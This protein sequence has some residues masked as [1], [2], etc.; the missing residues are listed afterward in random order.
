M[1][2][3]KIRR[4]LGGGGERERAGRQVTRTARAFAFSP[5]SAVVTS[6]NGDDAMSYLQIYRTSMLLF[7]MFFS[8]EL[9][10]LII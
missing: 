9:N 6:N 8:L 1:E 5:P 3:N 10:W 4:W 7:Y 2:N